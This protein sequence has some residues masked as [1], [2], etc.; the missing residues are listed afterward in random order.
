MKK[1]LTYISSELVPKNNLQNLVKQYLR[2]CERD[3]VSWANVENYKDDIVTAIKKINTAH[4]RCTPLKPEWDECFNEKDFYLR[5]VK[6]IDFRL[7]EG[8]D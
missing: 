6:C 8:E 3:I 2:S 4:P 1:Y 7:L 5:G